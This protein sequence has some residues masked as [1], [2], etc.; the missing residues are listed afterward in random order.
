MSFND[1]DLTDFSLLEL[2][3]LKTKVQKKID[4]WGREEGKQYRIM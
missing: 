3:A 4:A 1:I 2:Q